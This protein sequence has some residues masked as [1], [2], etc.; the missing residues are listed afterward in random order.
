M[1]LTIEKVLI[2]TP[3]SIFSSAPEAQL[4]DLSTIVDSVKYE[5][6]D[7]IHVLCDYTR[8]NLTRAGKT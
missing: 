3:M 7:L 4:V 5:A 6:G 2:L 1:L 8:E